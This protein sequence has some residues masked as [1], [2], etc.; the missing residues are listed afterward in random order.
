MEDSS[1]PYTE[2][3]PL[4]SEGHP[5]VSRLKQ[6]VAVCNRP[7][8]VPSKTFRQFPSGWIA[9]IKPNYHTGVARSVTLQPS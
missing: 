2:Q 9:R 4:P 8:P 3:K 7:A 6:R 1:C 5:M